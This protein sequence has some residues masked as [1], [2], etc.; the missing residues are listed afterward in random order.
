MMV[1]FESQQNITFMLKDVG[2][3]EDCQEARICSGLESKGVFCCYVCTIRKLEETL[4]NEMK[5][6]DNGD[7]CLIG[8]DL[9]R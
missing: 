4:A 7:N 9:G 3:L 8:S 1:V 5:G 2:T 6:L